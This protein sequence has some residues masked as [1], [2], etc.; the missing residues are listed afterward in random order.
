MTSQSPRIYIYKITFEEVS[1]YYYGVH[2]EKYFN[3]EYWGSPYTHKWVWN[4]YTPKKQILQFFDFTDEGWKEAQEIEK[5]LIKP[6]YN[7]DKWCLNEFCG[8]VISLKY[9]IKG[10]KVSGNKNK[11]LGL[12]ICGL[13]YDERVKYGKIGRETQEKNNLGVY[14]IT[15][16]QRIEY[17]KKGGNTCKE[18]NLGICGLSKDELSN[19][20]KIGGS[21]SYEMKV[22][23]HGRTKEQMTEDGKKGGYISGKKSYELGIGIHGRTKEQRIKDGKKGT[24]RAKE[25]GV[26]FYGIPKEK[27]SE[28]A[29]KVN[30]QKWECTETGYVANPGALSTYQKKRGIDTSKRRRIS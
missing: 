12:G 19:A 18:K 22:G 29:K 9:C 15:E 17:G 25:L 2:K 27:R 28:T 3:E 14:G 23:V 11:E 10:G 16:E 20:G 8:G 21:L 1:Y 30:S 24:Q 7:T 13:T 26:G 4:F 5:R 6:F